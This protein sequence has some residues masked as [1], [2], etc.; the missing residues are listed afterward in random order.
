MPQVSFDGQGLSIGGR[1]IFL[2]GAAVES[3]LWPR[4][5]WAQGLA[6]LRRRGINVIRTSAPWHLHEAMPGRVRFDGGLDLR[7]FVTHCREQGLWVIL[8]IGPVVGG[9]FAGGGL[10]AWISEVEGLRP[11]EPQD[12]FLQRVARWYG[13][14]LAQVKGLEAT[15][16][17]AGAGNAEPAGGLLAVQIE[18]GWE[19]GHEK[20]GAQYFTEL[21]RFVRE[22]GIE[23]PVLTA[24]GLWAGAEEVVDVWQGSE[25][26]FSNVRQLRRAQP[27]GPA[28]VE[29]TSPQALRRRDDGG[30]DARAEAA[31]DRTIDG[32]D[33]LRR[34][35]QVIAAGGQAIVGH[36]APE[37]HAAAAV[38]R[39]GD[40][41]LS[42][43]AVRPAL[44]DASAE[45]VHGLGA[46]SPLAHFV[47]SFGP[48]IAAVGGGEG[49]V[50]DPDHPME[51][52]PIVVSRSSGAT[53]IAFVF[54][55]GAPA[56]RRSTPSGRRTRRSKVD[57]GQGAITLVTP[58][59]VRIAVALGDAPVAWYPVGLDLHGRARLDYAGFSPIAFVDGR[60]LVLFGPAGAS[61]TLS[62]DGS[63]RR[64]EAPESRAGA[65]PRVVAHAALSVV[66][67]NAAQAAAML[68]DAQGIIIGAMGTDEGGALLRARGFREVVRVAADGAVR[69]VPSRARPEERS[70]A[71]VLG[72]W[73]R[74]STTSFTEGSSARFAS[75]DRPRSLAVYAPRMGLGWYRLVLPASNR[76][77]LIW[78]PGA[79]GS[80]EVFLDGR[81]L[82]SLGDD[83]R[84]PLR[85]PAARGA[86][87]RTLV[88]LAD[89]RGRSISGLA[90]SRAAGLR[91]DAWIVEAVRARV[92]SVEPSAFDPFERRI[93]VPQ[94][95]G[96][97]PER[98]VEVAFTAERQTPVVIDP[99][100][101]FYGAVLLQRKL[102]D[103]FDRPAGCFDGI[104]LGPSAP[105]W[106]PG[107]LK[108]LLVPLQPS[109]G[110]ERA[111]KVY[112]RAA[113]VEA[114]RRG[115]PAWG[116]ARWEAPEATSLEWN[117]ARGRA[118]SPASAGGPAWWSTHLQ[119]SDAC[120]LR[121]DGL[122]RGVVL[123]DGTI[124]G[125]YDAAHDR[126]LPLPP[127]LCATGAELLIFDV[128]GAAPTRVTIMSPPDARSS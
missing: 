123:L 112:R 74:A 91:D 41:A 76:E 94:A 119:T 73:R 8:R 84:L 42:S 68:V 86:R 81:R 92:K 55:P 102:V 71:Q 95:P 100:V 78:L 45:A 5:H 35:A 47:S 122:T 85:I 12:L 44:L 98:A 54:Q 104:V 120:E 25:D 101:P 62:V 128:Q 39:E 121:L 40:H 89:D 99:G 3:A 49:V 114:S 29:V 38:G 79:A 70:R 64:V 66:V 15:E 16:R 61:A 22:A 83:R 20:A 65:R 110:L 105:G 127:E 108:A 93:F 60:L 56:P 23:L 116:F 30:A 53:T 18:H 6:T 13:A 77:T 118:S 69:T 17:R 24:N 4:A 111:L 63:E 27:H 46:I 97:A 31:G 19:C 113:T 36:A 32:D 9:T 82:G 88:F 37:V 1:R 125:R 21:R 43:D 96:P 90:A 48:S 50:V 10:P 67:L 107:A 51:R 7:A 72:P 117:D 2:M 103:V 80:L 28:I 58:D 26:L 59:G 57:P 115:A 126:Q 33:L 14:V 87:E 106:A 109:P 75:L 34:V 11:R 52:P 124:V